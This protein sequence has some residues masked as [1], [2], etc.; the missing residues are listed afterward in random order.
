[1]LSDDEGPWSPQGAPEPELRDL[2]GRHPNYWFGWFGFALIWTCFAILDP[3]QALRFHPYEEGVSFFTTGSMGVIVLLSSV[4]LATHLFALRPH[5]TFD[6]AGVRIQN[7]LTIWRIGAGAIS[8]T[9]DFLGF[10]RLRLMDGRRVICWGLEQ[11]LVYDPPQ[12]DA[13]KVH[14]GQGLRDQTMSRALH[15]PHWFD[16]V[17]TGLLFL[18]ICVGVVRA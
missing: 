6:D 2:N 3:L 1:M 15:P 5:V 11:Y 14:E 9:D 18:Y 4:L 10:P 16:V 13:L 7:P 17:S 8:D 12:K